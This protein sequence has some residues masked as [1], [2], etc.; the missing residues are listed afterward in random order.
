MERTWVM[1]NVDL[2]LLTIRLGDFFKERKFE[3]LG[4]KTPTNYQISAQNSSS[5]KLLGFVNVTIE[6]EP[7]NFVIKLELNETRRRYAKYSA[8]LKIFGGGYLALQE[9]KSD[10][11]WM[12]LEKEFWPYAEN[13]ILNLTNTAKPSKNNMETE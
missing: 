3:V 11:A 12:K 7:N 1:K 4:E 8:L 13:S 10:E 2:T 9:V 6:G 5:F